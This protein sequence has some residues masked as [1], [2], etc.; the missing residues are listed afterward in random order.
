MHITYKK[1]TFCVELAAKNKK[2]Q[3]INKAGSNFQKFSL[4]LIKLRKK[5]QFSDLEPSTSLQHEL[6][7]LIFF[8]DMS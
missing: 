4:L 3:S 1:L 6:A 7:I 2:K 8:A 5:Y